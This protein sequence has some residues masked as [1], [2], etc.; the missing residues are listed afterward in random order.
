MIDTRADRQALRAARRLLRERTDRPRA[1]DVAYR[2]YVTVLVAAVVGVPLGR[3]AVLAM[4]PALSIGAVPASAVAAGASLV[5]LGL[6]LVGATF[7]PVIVS[8]PY[9]TAVADGP[10]DRRLTLRRAQ[11]RAHIVVISVVTVL[12]ALG[13]IAAAPAS[14]GGVIM[15]LVAACALGSVAGSLWL[16]GQLRPPWWMRV[17]IAA[18]CVGTAAAGL[19][20]AVSGLAL[21]AGPWGWAARVW[22]RMPQ[23]AVSASALTAIVL[24]LAAAAGGWIIAGSWRRRLRR[25]DLARQTA[26]WNTVA[27]LSVSAEVSSAARVLAAPPHGGRQWT[28]TTGHTAASAIMRRDAA[29]LLRAPGR[30]A[31][32]LVTSLAC[33][34]LV[35]WAVGGGF[36]YPAAALLYL[37]IGAWATGLR[38]AA[39]SVGAAALYGTSDRARLVLHAIVPGVASIIFCAVGA[40]V[41]AGAGAAVWTAFLAVFA[42]LLQGFSSLRGPLPLDLLTPIPSPVGDLSIVNVLVWMSDALLLVVVF[43]G[44]GTYLLTASPAASATALIAG[45]VIVVFWADARLSRRTRS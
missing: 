33:G 1:A 12:A 30:T 38:T 10:I 15:M 39:S 44:S 11:L 25:D 26:R 29:G 7:G 2:A 36:A 23:T 32:A 35:G 16:A 27:A 24:L 31:T 37:A 17:L 9:L 42:V 18:W 5:C 41:T 19:I 14:A 6:F 21:W 45:A 40:A 34:A 8:A 13:V 28:W 4:E 20:P 43:G 22:T 3:A